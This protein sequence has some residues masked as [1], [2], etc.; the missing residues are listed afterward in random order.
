MTPLQKLLQAMTREVPEDRPTA[1]Q[2][3]DAFA[4][5]EQDCRDRSVMA[6]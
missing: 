2:A 1:G 5:I 6:Y 4:A 3:L